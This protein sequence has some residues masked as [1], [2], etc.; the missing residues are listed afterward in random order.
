MGTVKMDL[1]SRLAGGPHY[2]ELIEKRLGTDHNAIYTVPDVAAIFSVS[3]WKVR[4]W[5]DDGR[6]CAADY[7]KDMTRPVDP[8][9]P[10]GERRPL[11]PLWRMT[12]QAILDH[13]K[14]MEAGI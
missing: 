6:I 11:R 14:R 13:A 12:R 1:V 2:V 9:K 8:E 10:D 4:E 5:I 3:E 7:N